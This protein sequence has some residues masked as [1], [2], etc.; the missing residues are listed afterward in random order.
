MGG[1]DSG[2]VD[3]ELERLADE[4]DS[5]DEYDRRAEGFLEL[6][7][8]LRHVEGTEGSPTETRTTGTVTDARRISVVDVPET[9]PERIETPAAV[10]FDVRLDTGNETTVYVEWPETFTAE[11][12]LA[13]LLASLDLSPDSFA[14]LYGSEVPLQRVDGRYVLDLPSTSAETDRSHRWVY[15]IVVCLLLW[16]VVWLANPSGGL[17]LLAWTLLPLATYFD[18]MY[19]REASDW[20]PHR[21]LW[22]L[23]A[24]V[25]VVNVPAGLFYL[26]KR[27]RALG[28]FWR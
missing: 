8:T 7:S 12:Q 6:E 23:L 19:V 1:S 21:Y 13:R 9:Y 3:R 24:A 20:D 16:G 26:Y 11:T 22:P 14:D 4:L 25:W 18:L 17:I 27:V 28:P 5:G 2:E 15:A 10:A